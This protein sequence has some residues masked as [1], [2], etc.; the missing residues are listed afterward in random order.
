MLISHQ[1]VSR[2]KCFD[3]C[4][5]Q[6]KFRY[7]LKVPR[8]GEEPFYFTY[9][10]IVHKIAEL[11]FENRGEIPIGE[12]AKDL[13]RGKY[14]LDDRGRKCPPIEE[15]YKKKF[16]RHLRAI[17][18][19]TNK[20]GTDGILEYGFEYD[21]DPP[22]KRNIVG[23]LDRLII[24]GD[25]AWIIDYKTTK[26]GKWQLNAETVK[27]DMQ[28]RAYARVVQREFG[29]KPENIKAAL[30]YLEGE[31]LIGCCYSEQ[32]L[33]QAEKALLG[34][35]KMIE[36]AD[37]DKVWGKVGWYCK[38]CDYESTCPFYKGEDKVSWDG[39]MG[40]MIGGW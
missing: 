24:R 8:P 38:N 36:A 14:D 17:Q 13:L 9:G 22:H 11:Y 2:K 27:E 20:I 10:S 40:N 7:H 39:D 12:I 19:L 3:Q 33:I 30:F 23:F 37:P 35:Y 16:Q 29:I 5:Q 15:E 28:L 32:S 25:K 31:K 4:A 18:N 21:L 26:K 1:S 34:S 6:Y